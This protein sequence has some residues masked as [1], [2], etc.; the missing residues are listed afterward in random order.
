MSKPGT[1][2][3]GSQSNSTLILRRQLQELTKRPVEGFSAGLLALDA[4]GMRQE[5][6]DL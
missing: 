2:A 1:P 4:T 6:T 3:E 5:E